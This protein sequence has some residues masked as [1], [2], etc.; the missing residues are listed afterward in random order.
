M[1]AIEFSIADLAKATSSVASDLTKKSKIAIIG[2]C[3]VAAVSAS[4]GKAQAFGVS[5]FFSG[6][7]DVVKGTAELTVSAVSGAYDIGVVTVDVT[8]KAVVGTKN[9]ITN[10]KTDKKGSEEPTAIEK[11]QKTIVIDGEE[12]VVVKKRSKTI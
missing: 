11:D 2:I 4:P 3:A 7:T 9:T 1:R 5:D 6:L 12:Y 8:K 10:M